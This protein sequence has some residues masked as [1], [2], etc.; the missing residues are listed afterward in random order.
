[1]VV[2]EWYHCFNRGVDKRNIFIDDQ[3]YRRFLALLYICNGT[4]RK[5]ISDRVRF[6]FDAILN[7]NVEERGNPIVEVGVYA[8]MPN[9]PHLMLK[10]I[11]PGGIALFMQR[12]STGYTMYFNTKYGRTG[13]LFAGTYKSRHVNGDTYLK[14]LVAYILLNPA[15]LFFPNFKQGM[16]TMPILKERLLDYEYS[17]LPDFFQHDRPHN[18]ILGNSIKTYYDEVPRFED[19]LKKAKAFALHEDREVKPPGKGLNAVL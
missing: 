14:Q 1:M 7:T 18:K 6:N 10:E 17:S 19:L 8:L 13:S 11:T 4:Y 16:F 15:E 2:G 5:R 9:H 12:V 3:D